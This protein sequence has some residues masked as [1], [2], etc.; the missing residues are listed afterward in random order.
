MN[1]ESLN[2]SI[3]T[4]QNSDNGLLDLNGTSIDSID[5][6]LEEYDTV[7]R[8]KNKDKIDFLLKL[9]NISFPSLMGF[10][11]EESR[12]SNIKIAWLKDVKTSNGEP[13][14]YLFKD[15]RGK[16]RKEIITSVY[17]G[18]NIG[19]SES[20]KAAE[21]EFEISPVPQQTANNNPFL[22]RAKEYKVLET[23]PLNLVKIENNQILINDYLRESYVKSRRDELEKEVNVQ[24]SDLTNVLNEEK[25]KINESKNVLANLK[26]NET[27]IN[28]KLSQLY[29]EESAITL[30]I[31]AKI[32]EMKKLQIE[33]REMTKNISELQKYIKY[34]ADWFRKL[35]FISEDIYQ[36]LIQEKRS[37]LAGDN[38]K[39]FSEIGNDFAKLIDYV[40]SFSFS[41][42]ILYPR[43]LLEDFLTLLRTND[44]IVLSGLS[45]S[46]K[47]QIV[48]SFAEALGGISKIIP[49]KPNWT[50]SEDLLGYYNPLQKSYLGT[51]FL[52]ALL[53]AQSNP[54]QLYLICL[55]E[56]N[57]ARVEYYF[58]D[59]LSSLEKRDELPEI[60]LYSENESEHVLSEFKAIIEILD[61][62]KGNIL[63]ES[64]H[65]FGHLL[66]NKE[67]N[68][69]LREI[70]GLNENETFLSLHAR[71]R[72]MV[73]GVLSIPGKL[74]FPQN[75]RIIG[76]VNIDETTHYLSPKVLDRSHVV[77]FDSP[78]KLDMSLISKQIENYNIQ[79]SKVYVHPDEF[80]PKRC[81]YPPYDINNDIIKIIRVWSIDYL[82]KIGIDIGL[83]TIRQV[84]N[85]S[86]LMKELGGDNSLILNNIVRHKLL[87]R[88]SVDGN[89]NIGSSN[90][91]IGNIIENLKEK[92]ASDLSDLN[93][94]ESNNA[95]EELQTLIE[96]AKGSDNIF[97][98]WA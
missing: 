82:E 3:I 41:K 31:N 97:N 32:E 61:S 25:N 28:R 26:I 33:E 53:E 44:F 6:L 79:P 70:I 36:S 1:D 98:Y 37:V 54:S 43:Y 50:S 15:I 19:L 90:V 85:Y 88:L 55:D 64:I 74:R 24:L 39:S 49:V 38:T 23:I 35:D 86:I 60:F 78:L 22:I 4:D 17:I 40:H 14:F 42:G 57:L 48:K 66:T 65:N 51:P 93:T 11:R 92:I 34:R 27:K 29:E 63:E 89:K 20:E 45:G 87:P 69:K 8:S 2:S 84:L 47:T 75:V 59:F 46:G 76:A 30:E 56:M 13:V 96:K 91:T 5:S 62:A 58:A 18:T 7:V 10:I 68:Q 83:R 72:R 71:L 12:P 16:L 77:K 95:V 81:D 94:D 80:S 67:I 21:I 52:D 9:W 73:S